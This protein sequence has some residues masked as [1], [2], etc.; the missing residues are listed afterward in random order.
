MR[1]ISM[2]GEVVSPTTDKIVPEDLR[3]RI[4]TRTS[5]ERMLSNC[6]LFQNEIDG[7]SDEDREIYERHHTS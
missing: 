1:V 7:L 4:F 6:V 2:K 5:R 3:R